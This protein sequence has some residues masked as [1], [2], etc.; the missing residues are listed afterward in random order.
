MK[1][2]C[3]MASM[4]KKIR[5]STW[6]YLQWNGAL[7]WTF[8]IY[9]HISF[10]GIPLKI[11]SVVFVHEL[12]NYEIIFLLLGCVTST[13]DLQPSTA[14]SN[15]SPCKSICTQNYTLSIATVKNQSFR[16]SLSIVLIYN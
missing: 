16:K 9:Q 5:I 4:L 11:E 6:G 7:L 12:I 8:I 1:N 3:K 2:K 15:Q 10:G 14:I 13:S